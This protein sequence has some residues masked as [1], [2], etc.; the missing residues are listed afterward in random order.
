MLTLFIFAVSL[1]FLEQSVRRM[2]AANAAKNPSELI[3]G[4]IFS[5]LFGGLVFF[6]FAH[7]IGTRVPLFPVTP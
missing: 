7:M 5:I 3:F 1:Y 4:L 6:S 2:V